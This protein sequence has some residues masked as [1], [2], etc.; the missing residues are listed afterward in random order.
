MSEKEIN[1]G[2]AMITALGLAFW[3]IIFVIV[4]ATESLW[5]LGIMGFIT[6]FSLGAM[7]AA[8]VLWNGDDE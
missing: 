1:K 7:F 8:I 5:I 2:R 4:N 6:V 3:F